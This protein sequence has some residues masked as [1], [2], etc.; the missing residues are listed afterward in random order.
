MSI[1]D[2]SLI[3]L[4]RLPL[5]TTL[6]FLPPPPYLAIPY[7]ETLA[8]SL[9]YHSLDPRLA[10]SLYTNGV[11]ATKELGTQ[12]LA[13]HPAPSQPVEDGM[14]LRRAIGELML[15]CRGGRGGDAHEKRRKEERKEEAVKER[16]EVS[17]EGSQPPGLRDELEMEQ[18]QDW[19][20]ASSS[21]F[22]FS[23][24]SSSSSVLP[25]RSADPLLSIF[26]H[27]DTLSFLDAHVDRRP[28]TVLAL[29]EKDRPTTLSP[30]SLPPSSF[31][32]TTCSTT[33]TAATIR[34]SA[35][36][37][38]EVGWPVLDKPDRDGDEFRV[39]LPEI[40]REEEI[41]WEGRVISKR[42]F[43]KGGAGGRW[44]E[45][46]EG[47]LLLRRKTERGLEWLS[48]KELRKRRSVSVFR[49]SLPLLRP[50]R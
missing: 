50:L 18:Y 4:D 33:T 12:G 39:V 43:D 2:P 3:P 7:L 37:Q 49:F 46:V 32:S 21:T 1:P 35:S 45:G 6:H 40:S 13:G 14:D 11:W 31:P 25:A 26:C 9:G 38:E 29:Y 47:K 15:A 10:A 16:G 20:R 24:T 22:S 48:S 41:G 5:Q 28:H 19:T 17:L 8:C 30:S 44:K 34:S 42:M 23:P 36:S 27:L